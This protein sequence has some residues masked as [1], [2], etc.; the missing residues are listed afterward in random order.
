M[1]FPRPTLS[2]LRR[3]VSA[4]IAAE[5]PE[6][7][8]FSNIGVVGD[9]QAGLTNGLYGYLDWI[10]RQ[11]VPFTATQEY[12]E[13]WAALKGVIRK[14]A[15][16]ASGTATF[17]GTE[18]TV[19]PSGTALTRGDGWSYTTTAEGVVAAGS[20][21]V[22]IEA[23]T[24]G[25][26]GNASSGEPLSISSA[27]AGVAASGAIATDLA[28]GADLED[29]DALRSR[30][31]QVYAAP[32]QG[33]DADDYVQWALA[34]PGV[35][36]AWAAPLGMGA[37]TVTLYFMM[38]DVRLAEGGF[39]QGTNGVADDED[40]DAAATGDQLIVADA[41]FPRQPVTALVY[42]VAPAANDVTLTIAGIAASPFLVR[43]RIATAV[44]AALRA[45]A[46]PGGV[47]NISAIEAAIAAVA[48]SAGF[49]LTEVE[50]S[51]GT[52]TPGPA[53]NIV[54][55]TGYLPVLDT[56]VYV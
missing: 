30:M 23:T 33:G 7:L 39:P 20:V 12:L 15:T 4:D 8:R 17:T 9:V 11:A 13:A 28:G 24:S 21:T 46:R 2:E 51:D 3:Q 22:P 29:E 5:I 48:G 19:L 43:A 49:V 6:L 35:T 34:V 25:A 54:S 38:D 14:P 47:T 18:G 27:V 36:R 1:P 40:R 45:D 16:S 55:D 37:G 53:G 56:I 26:G 52:V 44:R 32:P 10:A 31:L 42:A 50:V 41:L